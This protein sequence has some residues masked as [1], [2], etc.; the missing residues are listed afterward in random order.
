PA[1]TADVLID[2]SCELPF[3]DKSLDGIGCFAVLEHVTM[4]W[5][6]ADEFARVVKPGGKI[7]VDWPFLQPVHG[8]PSHYYNAT[9]EGLRNLFARDFEIEELRTGPHQGPDH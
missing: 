4:P 1:I 8:Y 6:M 2:P 9:R 7:Y 5:R 3:N